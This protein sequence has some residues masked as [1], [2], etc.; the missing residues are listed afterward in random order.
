MKKVITICLLVVTLLLGGISSEAKTTRS[1]TS[2]KTSRSASKSG[3]FSITSLL[4]K[5]TYHGTTWFMFNS[6]SNIEAALKKAG[7]SLKSKNVTKG[8]VEVGTEGDTA[9]GKIINYVYSK[10]GVTIEWTSFAIDDYP[11]SFGKDAI[12]IKFSDNDAKNAF[13]KSMK[14]NGYRKEYGTYTDAGDTIHI[15]VKG[16]T[17][18]LYGNWA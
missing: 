14:S 13:I 15:E 5:E 12:K 18:I 2:H 6:D 17:V 11:N 3:A 16:N 1:N 10:K 4:H 7:F 8:E 9:P